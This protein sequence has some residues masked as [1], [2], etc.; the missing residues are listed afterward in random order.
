MPQLRDQLERVGKGV[1]RPNPKGNPLGVRAV[2]AFV[3]LIYR[4]QLPGE[5]LGDAFID[6]FLADDVRTIDALNNVH[7]WRPQ[8]PVRLFHGRDDRTVPYASSV[9]TL[10]AMRE[11]GAGELVSLTDCRAQPAGHLQCVPPFIT[12]LLGQLAPVARDL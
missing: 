5:T 9:R 10:R 8:V 3:L 1:D 12:F 4:R 2:G 6:R 11:Q 7:D